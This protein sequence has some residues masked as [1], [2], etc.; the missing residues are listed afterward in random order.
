MTETLSPRPASPP[1]GCATPLSCSPHPRAAPRAQPCGPPARA[2]ARGARSGSGGSRCVLRLAVEAVVEEVN[3]ILGLGLQVDELGV[4][5]L[6]SAGLGAGELGTAVHLLLGL[7][8]RV[9]D[10]LAGD[11]AGRR[12]EAP[13]LLESRIADEQL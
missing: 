1:C 2:R 11:E 10:D 6:H 7:V 5:L 13:L 9:G 3:D 8:R 12:E 4:V